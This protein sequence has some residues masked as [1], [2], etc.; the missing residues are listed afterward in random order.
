LATD[1][2][3][4]LATGLKKADASLI[5]VIDWGMT[6]PL[7]VLDRGRLP[8]VWSA[9]PFQPVPKGVQ[10]P[11]PNPRLLGDPR[12]LW[13]AHTDGN[14]QF[15]GVNAGLAALAERQRYQKVLVAIYPD[16]NGRPVFQ[17]FRLVKQ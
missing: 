15:A 3:Y 6:V 13:L 10:P 14:E 17:T 7:D 5:G 4:P 1:A 16:R 11:L 9:E 12:V 2:I 8:L